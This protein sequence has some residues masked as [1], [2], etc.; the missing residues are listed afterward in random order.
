MLNSQFSEEEKAF[1]A[2]MNKRQVRPVPPPAP[3]T[4]E[5][6]EQVTLWDSGLKDHVFQNT[7]KFAL[8]QRPLSEWDAY[9]KELEGKNATKYLDIVNKAHERYKKEH[10]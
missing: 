4:T 3:L 10:G 6:R 1:Q 2:E 9:V 7:L 8:G 5:E